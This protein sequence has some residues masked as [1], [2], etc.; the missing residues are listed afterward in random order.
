MVGET[1]N[2]TA[3]LPERG[4][5]G[6]RHPTYF[7]LPVRRC[8]PGNCTARWHPTQKSAMKKGPVRAGRV[9]G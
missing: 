8:A 6:G 3:R 4:A 5:L 2:L 1:P 7:Q 9:R